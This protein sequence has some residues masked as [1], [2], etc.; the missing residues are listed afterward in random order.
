MLSA[1]IPLKIKFNYDICLKN[2][3]KK[4]TKLSKIVCMCVCVGVGV[5]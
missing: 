3:E 1:N 4:M 2:I 5:V